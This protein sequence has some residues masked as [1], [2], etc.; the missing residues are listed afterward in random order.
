MANYSE[1]LADNPCTGRCSNLAIPSDSYCSGCGRTRAE[2]DTWNSIPNVE[3]KL[4]NIFNWDRFDLKQKSTR[5]LNGS[6]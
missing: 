5:K 1:S 2:I 3:R 4:I 6:G